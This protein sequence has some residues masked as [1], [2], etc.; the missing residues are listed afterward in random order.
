MVKAYFF[1]EL[2][3]QP[4]NGIETPCSFEITKPKNNTS[5]QHYPVQYLQSRPHE[6]YAHEKHVLR[7]CEPQK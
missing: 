2:R 7:L 1:H 6:Y 4:L 5:P 3:Y